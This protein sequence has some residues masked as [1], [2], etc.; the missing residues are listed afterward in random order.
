MKVSRIPQSEFYSAA[1]FVIWADSIWFVI[2]FRSSFP[3]KKGSNH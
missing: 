3:M 1:A 2:A